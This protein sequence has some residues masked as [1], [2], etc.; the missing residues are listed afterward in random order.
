MAPNFLVIRWSG[1][2]DIVMTLPALAYL[3]DKYPGCHIS[4]LTDAP[5]AQI[6]MLSG[7]ADY[8]APLDRRG[9]AKGGRFSKAVLGAAGALARLRAIGI[10]V[11]FDLQGFGETAVLA[12]MSGAPLRVGRI[13]KSALRKLIYNR[14]INANWE[15]DHRSVYFVK[16]A[17]QGLGFS[18]PTTFDRPRIK[19]SGAGP[20]SGLVTLNMGASTES[21]R[22]PEQHFFL[23]ADKLSKKGCSIRLLLGPQEK[24]IFAIARKTA[25]EKGWE[26]A[27]PGS[28]ESLLDCLAQSSLLVSNDTGPGHLAAALGTPV[29]TLFSTGDPENVGPL[30]K[31][32][33][34]FRNQDDIK[35]IGVQEVLNACLELME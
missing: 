3:K 11:A 23:L 8:V 34:W 16:A 14:S 33:M 19:R 35:Q 6:P 22:W 27:R 15:K 25:L 31:R 20:V 30:A 18:P 12:A 32:R 21:R 29:I 17:A 9:F 10:D 28:M 26:L 1:M 7:L 2:G 24:H 5:F 4:Y 13:K